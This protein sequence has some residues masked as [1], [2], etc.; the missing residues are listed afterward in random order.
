VKTRS[1]LMR[2]RSDR[3][4]G[5]MISTIVGSIM[6]MFAA[7]TIGAVVIATT[8]AT[9]L[10]QSNSNL[11]VG[12]QLEVQNWEKTPWS[13]IAALDPVTTTETLQG[14]TAKVTRQ[15]V[16]SD[17]LN[18]FTLTIA[19]PR[20]TMP[21]A[22]PL[23]CSGA[24]TK[25]I[26]GCLT[27]SGSITATS[28]ELKPSLPDGITV[29][30][31]EQ[32]NGSGQNANPVLNPDFEFGSLGTWTT[33][34]PAAASVIDAAP[35]R[36]SGSKVLSVI[37]ASGVVKSNTTSTAAGDTW[38]VTAWVKSTGTAGQMTLGLDAADSV[39]VI[40]N[41][42]AATIPA[43]RNPGQWQMLQGTVVVPPK[44]STAALT[45]TTAGCATGC[46]WLVDDT[47]LLKT[48]AN[49][50]PSGDFENA[51]TQWTLTNSTIADSP[52]RVSPGTSSLSF[53]GDNAGVTATAISADIPV[54]AGRTY[55]AD[56]WAKVVGATG[57]TGTVSLGAIWPNGSTSTIE[58]S[59]LSGVS[60]ASWSN[61]NL[62]GSVVVPAGTTSVKL[63]VSSNAKTSAPGSTGVLVV[64][65]VKMTSSAL[66]V[67]GNPQS[68]GFVRIATIDSAKIVAGTS[69]RVSYE[70]LGAIDNT[71]ISVGVFCS[72][73]PTAVPVAANTMSLSTQGSQNWF[74]TRVLVPHV[75][76][77]KDCASPEMHIYSPAGSVIDK[78]TI[79]TLSILTVLAGVTGTG[80]TSGGTP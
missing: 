31:A 56:F 28:D 76:R 43:T 11:T 65:D 22:H 44:T 77:L 25:H 37:E 46:S 42:V 38:A 27:L 80:H 70:H 59:D 79:G 17:V 57:L 73:D 16:F 71:P 52:N 74:W 47:S 29:L 9:A 19:V 49:L 1:L 5:D 67:G 24:L 8:N 51:T 40:T 53:T 78:A 18:A 13:D 23:D 39:G 2:F 55:K 72:A 41:T 12:L 68:G 50:A 7:V 61:V 45:L 33:T 32:V 35:A 63:R 60:S 14:H 64:D 66:D 6:F 26:T 15:V 58:S 62:P 21:T 36:L 20:S 10:A 3:G 34:I 69:I 54:V 4:E 30:G 48:A 75:E